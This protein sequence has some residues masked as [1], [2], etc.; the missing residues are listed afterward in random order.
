MLATKDPWWLTASAVLPARKWAKAASGIIVSLLVLTA[1]AD[2]AM[3]LPM[4][5]SAFVAALRAELAAMVAAVVVPAVFG[6]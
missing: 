2:D 3:P 1:A 4:F 6:R 5:A